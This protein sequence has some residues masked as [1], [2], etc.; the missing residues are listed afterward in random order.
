MGLLGPVVVDFYNSDRSLGIGK[1]KTLLLG[2]SSA[3]TGELNFLGEP[4]ILE[5][6][7]DILCWVLAPPHS[8]HA[9]SDLFT[10][11]DCK[12]VKSFWQSSQ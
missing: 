6:H 9:V 10:R 7:A 4:G 3:V 8:E 12:R 2:S 11:V 5:T 1:F